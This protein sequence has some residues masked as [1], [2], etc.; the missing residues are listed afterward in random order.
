MSKKWLWIISTLV[1]TAFLLTACAG[2]AAPVAQETTAPESASEAAPAETVADDSSTGKLVIWHAYAGQPDKE[3]FMKYAMDT[4]KEKYP[5]IAVEEVGMEHSSYKVKLN[6]AMATGNPPDVFYTLPGAYLGA[7]VDGDQVFPLDEALA[8]DGWQDSMLESAL[9]RVR[10][11]GKTYAVPIDIDAA[12]MWYNVSLFEKYGWEVPTTYDEFLALS[13]TIKAEG[14]IPVALG[15][16]DSWPATF[17]FQAP[18]LR[19]VETGIVDAFNAG[20]ANVSFDPEAVKG[21]EVIQEVAA[22]GYFPEGAN[23]MS[24]GEA[25]MLFL[26]GQAAM[27]LNGTWQI[28]MAADAPDDFE[29]GYFPFMTFA[30]GKEDQSD[31]IAGVAACFA[32]AKNA[33]DKDA[34]ILFL[35]HMTSP[36]VAAK[37]IEIRKTM[38]TVKDAITP[39][40]AGPT[41]YAISTE[42]VENASSLDA[43]YDTAMPPAAVDT[44]YTLIQG[45]IDQSITPEEAATRLNDAMRAALQ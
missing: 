23:G 18:M 40:N 9:A 43:F 22:R 39:E 36:E 12:V 13:E 37:Y 19:R 6:T 31:V 8:Q 3:E 44:Y 4:F 32:I 16:K 38:V 34:A 33:P 35:K 42:V 17:W 10:A 25:N 5:N 30:D 29:L 20:D 41:L 7:F 24:D 15:N 21:F 14:I 26:N 11:D 45:V 28:G 1:V 27:V 2:P